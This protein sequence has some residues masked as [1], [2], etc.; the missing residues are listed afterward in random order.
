MMAANVNVAMPPSDCHKATATSIAS[1]EDEFEATKN[2]LAEPK[3]S[4]DNQDDDDDDEE[5]DDDD[6]YEVESLCDLDLDRIHGQFEDDE[7][8]NVMPGKYSYINSR[9]RAN[10][11][12]VQM[13]V[14]ELRLNSTGNC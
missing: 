10:T 12:K 13:A 4:A 3:M 11:N 1:S 2:V 9:E 6:G 5:W 7:L 8:L 14:H